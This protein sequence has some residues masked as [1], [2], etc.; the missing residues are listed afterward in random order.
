MVRE[1]VLVPE[2]YKWCRDCEQAKPLEDFCRNRNEPRGRAQYC[3][4]CHNARSR[5]TRER[6]YGGGREYHLQRRYGI[7]QVDVDRMLAAQDGKCAVCG[8]ADPEH[9]DHDHKTGTVRG[10][11]CFNCNQAL[12]NVRDSLRVLRGLIAYLDPE[13]DRPSGIEG[14]LSVLVR[15][16]KPLPDMAWAKPRTA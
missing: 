2:G 5:E 10:L 14:R 15:A 3:K 7:G 1:P 11:L 13:A 12:G 16:A 6:L 8:K 4:V 9:V